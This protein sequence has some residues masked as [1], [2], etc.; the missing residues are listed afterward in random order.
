MHNKTIMKLKKEDALIT[1]KMY[2]M[3]VLVRHINGANEGKKS[4]EEMN[5][6]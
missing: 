4:T 6:K 3:I 1:G 5:D 2:I